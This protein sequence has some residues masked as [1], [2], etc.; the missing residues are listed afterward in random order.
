MRICLRRKAL[1]NTSVVVGGALNS[2]LMYAK[3]SLL[4]NFGNNLFK[5]THHESS[6]KTS[7]REPDCT[8]RVSGS[9]DGNGCTR[10]IT[11]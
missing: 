5:E 9:S 8:G 3:D 10:I 11:K 6:S 7:F 4:I 2:R 1:K